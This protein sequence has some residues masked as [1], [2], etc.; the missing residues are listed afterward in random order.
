MDV[1]P[2]LILMDAKLPDM[3]GSEVIRLLKQSPL[4]HIPVI[5]LTDDLTTR[6]PC[7]DAGCDAYL[8]EP[9]RANTLQRA[10]MQLTQ[11]AHSA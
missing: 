1:R 7:F 5:V 3:A 2:D 11:D 6:Q 4:A 10:I 9:V 8:N